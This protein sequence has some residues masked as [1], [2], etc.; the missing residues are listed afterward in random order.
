MLAE[1]APVPF[2]SALKALLRRR[3]EEV[4][5]LF[6]ETVDFVTPVAR[7]VEL[8]WALETIARDPNMLGDAVSLLA[9]LAAVDPGGKF[10]NRPRSSLREILLP[11]LPGTNAAARKRIAS[12][13][14]VAAIDESVGWDLAVSLLPSTHSVS[15]MTARPRYR[16]A[17]G[18]DEAPPPSEVFMGYE[19]AA[20]LARGTRV[21]EQAGQ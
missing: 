18:R 5:A 14:A 19:A 8:L 2:V 11:W 3:P 7:H 10:G 12:M 1:A 9:Q 17:M 16:E 4:R 6:R 21:H 15:N 13:Q 20:A